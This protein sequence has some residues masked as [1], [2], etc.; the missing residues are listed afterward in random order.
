LTRV[1]GGFDTESETA[2]ESALE[3]S[4]YEDDASEDNL[5]S[6][7]P[8]RMDASTFLPHAE[9]DSHVAGNNTL[10]EQEMHKKLTDFESSS[11]P[12]LSHIEPAQAHPAGED[13][14]FRFGEPDPI[15]KLEQFKDE[16][17]SLRSPQTPPAAYKTPTPEEQISRM[18]IED[19]DKSPDAPHTSSLE[20]MSS[21]PTAA[22]A[23]RTV[24]R[25]QS[26][27]T[28]G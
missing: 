19:D 6:L 18:N 13:E 26:M 10:E 22:A 7:L 1:P 5:S 3:Q 21:S 23:A 9:Q 2:S 15:D 17:I 27:T 20:T 24:S 16:Q 11:L 14:T 8:E 12:E 4:L 25:V 28:I